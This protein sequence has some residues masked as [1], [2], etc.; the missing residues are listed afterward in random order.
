MSDKI[1]VNGEL[2]VNVYAV[3]SE[4]VEQGIAC[5]LRRSDKHADDPLTAEQRARVEEH[6]DR[7]VMNAICDKFEFSY[8]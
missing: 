7:E 5:G 6:I 3:L 4:C 1:P 8:E 2:K